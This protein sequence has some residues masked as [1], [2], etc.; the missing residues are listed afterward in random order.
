MSV[1]KY[2]QKELKNARKEVSQLQGTAKLQYVWDYYK[3]W[4]IGIVCVVAFVIYFIVARAM[5]PNDNWFYITI[6][7]TQADAD[8]NSRIWKDFVEYSGY[9]TRAKKSISTT[10]TS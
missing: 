2:L 6:A 3:L 9:D 10:H 4:I 5:T 1:K 7:N 8:N